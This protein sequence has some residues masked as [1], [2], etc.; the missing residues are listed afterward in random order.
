MIFLEYIGSRACLSANKKC[1]SSICEVYT[2]FLYPELESLS[3][4]LERPTTEVSY[5][6]IYIKWFQ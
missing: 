2:F 1:K 3:V 5:K 6:S 4:L